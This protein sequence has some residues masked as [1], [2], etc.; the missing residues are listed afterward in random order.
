VPA[1]SRDAAKAPALPPTVASPRRGGEI[2]AVA[3]DAQASAAHFAG[4]EVSGIALDRERAAAHLRA[5][6]VA[7]RAEHPQRAALHARAD[8]QKP[9]ALALDHERGGWIARV[10]ARFAS[11]HIEKIA[12]RHRLA[13]CGQAEAFERR[14]RHRGKRIRRERRAVDLEAG[15]CLHT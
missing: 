12:D 13:A 3:R 5:R 11:R 1:T 4:R 7:R 8:A 15:R 10:A 2:A 9:F 14:E 6:I